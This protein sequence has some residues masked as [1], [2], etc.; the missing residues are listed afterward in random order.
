MEGAGITT[1]TM[2]VVVFTGWEAVVAAGWTSSQ[3]STS[4]SR[5]RGSV[6]ESARGVRGRTIVEIV[7]PA[8]MIRGQLSGGK[9]EKFRK[10]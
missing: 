6:A 2:V 3:V 10:F 8:E 7:H 1:R 9:F 5:R 4:R